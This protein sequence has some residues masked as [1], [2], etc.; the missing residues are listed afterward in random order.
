MAYVFLLPRNS[1]LMGGV[2][3]DANSGLFRCSLSAFRWRAVAIIMHNYIY[4]A[5]PWFPT[6]WWKCASCGYH[7]DF[8]KANGWQAAVP[9]LLFTSCTAKL[10]ARRT[11]GC[12]TVLCVF[13]CRSLES[14]WKK[15][16]WDSTTAT[17]RPRPFPSTAQCA[18]SMALSPFR[19]LCCLYTVTCNFLSFNSTDASLI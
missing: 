9:V 17:D 12:C 3:T 15:H 19:A 6:L 7:V 1:L 16:R 4:A 5:Y 11:A 14:T 18:H 10:W 2:N 8:A 13:N